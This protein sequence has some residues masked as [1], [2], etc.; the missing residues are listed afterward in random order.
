MAPGLLRQAAGF[1]Y[2]ELSNL[3]VPPSLKD[4]PFRAGEDSQVS[5]WA[6]MLLRGAQA[7]AFYD[8]PFFGKYPT[9][10]RNQPG[11]GTLT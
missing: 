4:D 11:K 7:L 1:R 3:R 10:T 9:I 2:Q 6:E 8:H 5:K